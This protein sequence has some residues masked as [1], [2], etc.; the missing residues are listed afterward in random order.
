MVPSLGPTAYVQAETPAHPS[1]KFY[2]VVVGHGIGLVAGFL[3]VGLFA[4]WHDPVLLTDHQ[5]TLPR[6]LAA[7]LASILTLL[8]CLSVKASHP[9]AG[10][11]TLLVALGSVVS[12]PAALSLA[13]GAV[14]IGLLGEWLRRLRL[15]GAVP[16]SM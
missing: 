8:V 9:P 2:H 15:K 13:V 6:V 3:S 5:L 4:A 11:T 16:R 7:T 1:A 12:A 10:A 14:L